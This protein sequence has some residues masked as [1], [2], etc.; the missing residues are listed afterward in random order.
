[1]EITSSRL[2]ALFHHLV[3]QIAA[4]VLASGALLVNARIP[5]KY[6]TLHASCRFLPTQCTRRRILAKQ[7][8][9]FDELHG[10]PL[11][12]EGAAARRMYKVESVQRLC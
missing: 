11:R 7:W 8:S 5:G 12:E 3:L 4:E 6:R 9:H 1:M 10:E 2:I